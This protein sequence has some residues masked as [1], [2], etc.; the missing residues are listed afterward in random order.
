MVLR[1]NDILEWK[2]IMENVMKINF[3][4]FNFNFVLKE[5]DIVVDSFEKGC[6]VVSFNKVYG[7]LIMDCFKIFFNEL[8]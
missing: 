4:N 8:F 5:N 6:L 3:V 7:Y 2:K 1:F